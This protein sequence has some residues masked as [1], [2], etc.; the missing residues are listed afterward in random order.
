MLERP[1]SSPAS[2][3]FAA[4]GSGISMVCLFLVVPWLT[5]SEPQ[6]LLL[7][8]MGASAVLLFC[9]PDGA[10]SGPWAVFGGHSISALL[11]VTAHLWIPEPSLAGA[12]AVGTSIFFMS[13]LRCLHPPGGATA[14]SAVLAG[15]HT[16]LGYEF[17]FTPVLLNVFVLLF[18]A[19][20]F[21]RSA[22]NVRPM[23]WFFGPL[24]RLKRRLQQSEC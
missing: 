10:L 6:D 21:H 16:D 2:P 8:S 9:I 4:L 5:Q 3:L 22:A 7:A 24:C 13:I 12:L 17:L 15:A 1:E 19:Y 18:V 23:S 14:L 20:L 11:G